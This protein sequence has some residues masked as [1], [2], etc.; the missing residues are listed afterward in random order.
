MR[1]YGAV[2]LVAVFG[3]TW[4]GAPASSQSETSDPEAQ[5]R[6]IARAQEVARS[7]E[8]DGSP[9]RMDDVRA[10][11]Q[12]P[13]RVR[14]GRG[15]VELPTDPVLA[16]LAGTDRRDFRSAVARLERVADELR[17]AAEVDSLDPGVL[18]TAL[19]DAYRE[20]HARPTLAQRLWRFAEDLLTR[21]VE[22]LAGA[23]RGLGVGAA[24]LLGLLAA[25]AVWLLG[26]RLLVV[27]D[28]HA[29]PERPAG[30]R[31]ADWRREADAA[32]AA[33]DLDRAVRA[34]YRLLI[35]QLARRGLIRDTPSLTPAEARRAVSGASADVE[36][37]VRRAT[38]VFERMAYGEV[39]PEQTDVE[40]MRSAVEAAAP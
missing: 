17:A 3:L 16:E 37:A 36:D 19:K 26:R 4:V 23:G 20:V 22:A 15:T 24:I 7:V 25:G 8:G 35:H 6:A 31:P 13:A 21:I 10:A 5:L 28:E 33:G 2:V 40:R 14:L 32:L 34:Q 11:L 9:E 38:A 12:R 39:P 30:E 1:R 18:D 27:A 29:P